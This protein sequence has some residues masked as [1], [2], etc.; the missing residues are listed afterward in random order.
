[1]EITLNL[2]IF[3]FNA[4]TDFLR[5]Y[6]RYE[7]EYSRYKAQKV[8][9]IFKEIRKEDEAF[10]FDKDKKSFVKINQKIVRVD[11]LISDVIKELGISLTIEPISE[12]HS[13]RDFILNDAEFLQRLEVFEDFINFQDENRYKEYRHL[14]YSSNILS[15]NPDYIGDALI[16]LSYNLIQKYP[17]R[18]QDILKLLA[19][20]SSGI[21]YYSSNLSRFLNED[22]HFNLD[23]KVKELKRKI[24]SNI[25][26]EV[27]KIKTKELESGF[28]FPKE[29]KKALGKKFCLIDKVKRVWQEAQ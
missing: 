29:F 2:N 1:M 23:E 22:Y 12:R 19:N 25:D 18:E 16:A 5:Y 10:G 24:L 27:T 20:E 21:W 26:T 11:T 9:D 3:R 15:Y 13:V 7:V 4:K 28:N 8:I 14:F 17:D 6:K